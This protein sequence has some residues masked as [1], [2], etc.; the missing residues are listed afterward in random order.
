MTEF[1]YLGHILPAKMQDDCDITHEVR[2]MYAPTNMLVQ[3]FRKC[4]L[5]EKLAIFKA[6]Y[7][8]CFYG[9]LLWWNLIL[10]PCSNLNTVR[11]SV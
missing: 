5:N 11:M 3:R 7:F 6:S 4:T 2:N 8:M 10:V 9:I 1:K